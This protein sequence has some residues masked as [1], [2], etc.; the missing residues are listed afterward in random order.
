MPGPRILVIRRDNIGDLVCTTP[1]L[2]ALRLQLPD[3]YLAALVTQ[4]NV[5][6]LAR[7]PDLDAVHSYTKAKHRAEGDSILRIYARR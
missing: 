3:A 5:A 2:H 6:V 1:L 7:N 4:Y